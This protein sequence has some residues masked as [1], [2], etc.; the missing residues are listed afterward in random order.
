[1]KLLWDMGLSPR[2]A[3]FLRE[4]G[5]DAVHLWEEGLPR[6][7]DEDV[8]QKAAHEGRILVTFDL[9]FSRIL[10]LQR[11]SNPS[12]ILFRLQEFTTDQVNHML[13]RLLE[14]YE[15]ELAQGA[16]IV[17]DPDRVRTRRLPIW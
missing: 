11:A 16:V 8:A 3:I 6:I 9:D 7:A 5:H 15:E 17:V 1:M 10:A 12:M 2:T 13:G 4:N 14:Q